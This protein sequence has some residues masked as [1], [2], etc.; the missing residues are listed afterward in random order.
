MD[1]NLGLPEGVGLV[2]FKAAG[3]GDY[4]LSRGTD[5]E[6][7]IYKGVRPG[8]AGAS[9]RVKPVDGYEF[10][11]VGIEQ[12]ADIKAF[13]V[14]GRPR[15]AAVKKLAPQRIQ[16]LAQFTVTNQVAADEIRAKYEELRTLAG[17]EGAGSS[18]TVTVFPAKDPEPAA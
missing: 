3:P 12:V 8:G 6:F 5:G 15:F 13:T 9:F 17:F 14:E 11:Q 7:H 4:E 10:V 16:I 2:D 1:H 18:C